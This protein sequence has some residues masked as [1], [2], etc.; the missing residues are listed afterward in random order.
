[1]GVVYRARRDDGE[2]EEQVAVKLLASSM[3]SAEAVRRFRVERQALATLDHPDIVTL[4][5][6]GV[7]ATGQAYPRDAVGVGRVDCGVL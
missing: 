6:G 7:T 1:M 4:L 5:D 2:Y 3:H